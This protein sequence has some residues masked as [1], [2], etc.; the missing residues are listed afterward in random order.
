DFTEAELRLIPALQLLQAAQRTPMQLPGL[1]WQGLLRPS[2]AADEECLA[3]VGLDRPETMGGRL[4][5]PP[6]SR[7]PARG[8]QRVSLAGFRFSMKAAMPSERSSSAKVAW[9]RLRSTLRPS[10]SG[11]SKARLMASFAIAAAGRDIE[12][13]FS[14]AVITS[15]MSWSTGTT[16]LTRPDRSA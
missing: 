14:A 2:D 13:T 4:Y 7:A 6:G 1:L 12:A 3:R 10:D 5:P 8:P 15:P 11:V 16:R 9:N